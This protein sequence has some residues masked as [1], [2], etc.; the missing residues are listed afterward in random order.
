MKQPLLFAL[1][2]FILFPLVGHSQIFKH[3][4][5]TIK[6]LKH[7]RFRQVHKSFDATLKKE[8]GPLRLKKIW[9]ALEKEFGKYES[10]GE[11]NVSIDKNGEKYSTSI[12]FKKGNLFLETSVNERGKLTMI[13]LRP[14]R[15]NLPPY[16]QSLAFNK[17]PI[18]I[19]SG[20]YRLPGDIVYPIKLDTKVPLVIFVHGSGP[21]NRDEEIGP[22]KVF[23]DLS[24]GLLSKG[25]ACMVYDKRTE[26]Y[27]DKYD[28]IQFT[29][30]DETI[31]DAL[32]AFR[33]A[34]TKENIDTNRIFILGHSL[35]GYALP[36]ILKNCTNVA[37]GISLAG[38]ARPIEDLIEYQYNFLTR[39]DGKLTLAERYFLRKELKKI[40]FIRSS[41]LQT[42]KPKLRLLAYWPSEFWKDI[43]KYD[44]VSE[45]KSLHIPMLFVQGDRDYQV[46]HV[47]FSLWKSGYLEQK[48]WS[49]VNFPKL[50]HLFVEGEGPPNPS[51]YWNGGNVPHYVIE[52]LSEW[53]HQLKD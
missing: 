28:S 40:N 30:W 5:N 4:E 24:L 16:G 6:Y 21:N 38:C 17:E 1:I 27:S 47:D 44:P 48:D 20:S 23:K 9:L 2:A 36:L 46:T 18:E 19:K 8:V 39:L 26:V 35:G 31:D 42:A 45:L 37:G 32:E 25:V 50:N 13:F 14:T 41:R 49:F 51:E 52:S 11:T 12:H 53:I 3:Q 15:Y 7:H 33:L 29:L 43:N 34:K 10:H 22:I